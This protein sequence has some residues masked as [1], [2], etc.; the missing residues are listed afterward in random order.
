MHF[1]NEK[2]DDLRRVISQD[3]L[4]RRTYIKGR[5]FKHGLFYIRGYFHFTLAKNTEYTENKYLKNITSE[6]I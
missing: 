5:N 6:L 3:P 4:F 1:N 2:Q